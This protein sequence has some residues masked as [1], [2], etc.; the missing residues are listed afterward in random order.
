MRTNRKKMF[1]RKLFAGLT[2]A[3]L[4]V[5]MAGVGASA[6][7][8]SYKMIHKYR[9]ASAGG[10]ILDSAGNLYG[11]DDGG[12]TTSGVCGFGCGTVFE[13]SPQAG[14]WKKT[15]LYEFTGGDDGEDPGGPLVFDNAGNLYGTTA[16]GGASGNGVVFELS[17]VAGGGWTESVLYAFPGGA[18]GTEPLNGVTLDAAGNIYGT[19]FEGG[20]ETGVVFE[21]TPQTGGGWNETVLYTF[22]YGTDGGLPLGSLI[23]DTA[24]NLYGTTTSG[25]DASCGDGVGG[26]GVVFELTPNASGWVYNVIFTFNGLDGDLPEGQMA[27]DAAG[28]LY[29]A[30]AV[31]G[32]LTACDGSGCGVVFKLSPGAGE[33]WTESVLYVFRVAGGSGYDGS[34][35]TLINGI[36][37]DSA[38]NLYG[39]A[40]S[41]GTGGGG[42]NGLV[43]KLSPAPGGSWRETVLHDFAGGSGGAEPLTGV[44]LDTAGNLF[45]ATHFGGD[46][47][48]CTIVNFGLGCGVAF[49]IRQ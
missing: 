38:G 28:N 43:F 20:I 18:N 12:K 10:L 1:A 9:G 21:L 32:Q 2:A 33:G 29:G 36:A 15:T 47:D 45:G 40:Q 30:T 49:E 4:A 34:G 5:L 8:S 37:R 3:A 35:G 24:G 7:A 14:R 26:C 19:T 46:L 17:P 25:G 42:G 48:K 22:T 44:T 13:L 41:G 23:F 27:F 39:T 16:S 11:V 6:Q 31:G